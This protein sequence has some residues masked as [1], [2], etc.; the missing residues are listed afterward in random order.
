V[1][2]GA[3]KGVRDVVMITLGTGVGGARSSMADRTGLEGSRR[4]DRAHGG[5]SRRFLGVHAGLGAHR[6]LRRPL[7]N[8]RARESGRP[9]PRWGD[10]RRAGGN[11]EAVTAST[12]SRPH[13]RADDIARGILLEIGSILGEALVGIVNLLNPQLIVVGGASASRPVCFV[14]RAAEV[15]AEK[16][17]RVGATSGSCARCSAT[18]QAS[19]ARRR[20]R[21]TNAT[22]AEATRRARL[23]E[24]GRART[25]ESPVGG[26]VVSHTVWH[27]AGRRPAA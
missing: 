8:R 23:L 1:R 24:E 22:A 3:A 11:P 26:L 2:F 13:W 9:R 18:T 7:G 20:S 10:P 25:L 5:Q 16:R 4:R 19:S 17:L 14:T 6:V 15:V 12:S 21:S 27:G